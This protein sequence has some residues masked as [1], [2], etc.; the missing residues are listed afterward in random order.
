[1]K[2]GYKFILMAKWLSHSFDEPILRKRSRGVGIVTLQFLGY[3]KKQLELLILKERFYYVYEGVHHLVNTSLF[4]LKLKFCL[5]SLR[6]T[7][8]A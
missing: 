1:M 3:L 4:T 7:P 6:K 5:N 2:F 8:E